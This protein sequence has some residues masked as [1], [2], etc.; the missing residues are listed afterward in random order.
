MNLEK[1]SCGKMNT[2]VS[3]IG[4]G[5][6]GHTI[7]SAILDAHPNARIAEEQK[8]INK[9]YRKELEVKEILPNLIKSGWGAERS[10]YRNT[11]LS[12]TMLNYQNPL[13]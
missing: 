7:I 11:S 13:L 12:K 1:L 8:Y 10:K 9:W 4:E 2:W 3:F 5:R 6:S